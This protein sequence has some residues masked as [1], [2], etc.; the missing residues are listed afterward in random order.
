MHGDAAV[1]A[2]L[3]VPG[4]LAGLDPQGWL[5][6]GS[7]GVWI[8]VVSLSALRGNIWPKLLAYIGISSGIVYCLVVATN[9]EIGSGRDGELPPHP[10]VRTGHAQL[11]HPAPQSTSVA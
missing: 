9:G 7:V 3:T 4:T 2:A 8:L 6:W 11:T 10:P 1:K 5:R